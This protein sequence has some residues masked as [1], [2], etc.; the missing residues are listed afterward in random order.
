LQEDRVV[1]VMQPYLFP[2]LG[3]FQLVAASDVFVFYDDVDFIK[4]G[5][6]NRNKILINDSP[7]TFTVP[8]HNA[9]QNET[10]NDVVIHEGWRKDK[11]MK[12]IRMTYSNAPFFDDAFS[13]VERVISSSE[14]LISRLAERSVRQVSDYL[15]LEVDFHRS[16]DL[17]VDSSMGRA[18]RLIALTKHLGASTYVNMEGGTELYEKSYFSDQGVD[19]YFLTPHLPKYSQYTGDSFH[20]GLSIIDVMMNV[21]PSDIQAM[22][23]EHELS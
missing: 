16:S 23:D 5:W 21:E 17:D 4:R 8:C 22:L 13:I 11:L 19:L 1:A 7:H 15:G 2:Y 14:N 18:D 10:I 6:I 20:P 12:K 3:Y 9:S